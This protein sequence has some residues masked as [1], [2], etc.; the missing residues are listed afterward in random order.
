MQ[1]RKPINRMSKEEYAAL[2]NN[3]N[4]DWTNLKVAYENLAN[5]IIES[6]CN[7]YIG[8]RLSN[9][10]VDPKHETVRFFKS[11]WY[12]MLTNLDGDY[13]MRKLDEKVEEMKKN[14]E[15]QRLENLEEQR[16]RRINNGKEMR[17][18]W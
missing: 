13:L 18:L 2:F 9:N 11:E 17:S 4:I 12:E 7:A 15:V 16:L 14:Q 8:Y 5:A 6:A 1:G 10:K 3:P